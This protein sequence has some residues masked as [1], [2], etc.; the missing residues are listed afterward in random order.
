[1]ASFP[2]G[3]SIN[4]VGADRRGRAYNRSLVDQ[5]GAQEGRRDGRSGLNH[6]PG[7]A[8]LGQQLQHRT[9]VEPVPCARH[10]QHVDAGRSQCLFALARSAL[11]RHEPKRR[12]PRGLRQLACQREPQHGVEDDTHRRALVHS[13]QA[14]REQRI[15]RDNRADAGEH[16][17]V[18]RAHQMDARGRSRAGNA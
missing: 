12:V 15:I 13:R 7:D 5:I 14:T 8:A 6:E 2:T 1:M 9:E 17:I 3:E 11:P 10:T 16:R 18:H 4:S